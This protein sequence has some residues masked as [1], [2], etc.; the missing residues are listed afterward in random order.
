[1]LRLNTLAA[2]RDYAQRQRDAGRSVGL[3]PTM[4]AL[5]AGHTSLFEEAAARGDVV[6]ATIF[7][8]PRQFGNSADLKAYPHTPEVDVRLAEE[9]GVDCLVE[10]TLEEMW[11]DYPRATSTTVQVRGISELL[12]GAGRPGHFDGVASVVAK[13]FAVTGP[14]RAYFGE[15]D[16]Q[17]IAVVRQMVRDLALPVEVVGCPIVRDHDG[18]ALSSRNLLLSETARHQALALS[19]ALARVAHKGLYASEMRR[20]MRALM[21]DAGVQVAYADVVDPVTF[22]PT[23]DDEDGERRALVAGIVESI[24]LIDNASVVVETRRD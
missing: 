23:R 6:L 1:M 5:H 14:C 7:V 11:P 19:H 15:K 21:Q 10:P 20:I 17:Q 4:G 13:L 3:V 18:L 12:E 8:N 9:H 2:W 16:F 22:V 24:R